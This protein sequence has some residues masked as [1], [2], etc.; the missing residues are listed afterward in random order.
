MCCLYAYMLSLCV[1]GLAPGNECCPLFFFSCV[2]VCVATIQS[3][4]EMQE[5]SNAA[6]DEGRVSLIISI[7]VLSFFLVIHLV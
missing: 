3:N 2:S 4:S 1:Y 5:A 7:L 6:G